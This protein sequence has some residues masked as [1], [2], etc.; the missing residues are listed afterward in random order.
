M[1]ELKISRTVVT[2]VFL[3]SFA[4]LLTSCG[5]QDVGVSQ[6]T[7]TSVIS[8]ADSSSSTILEQTR[9]PFAG[10]TVTPLPS[11]ALDTTLIPSPNPTDTATPLPT[12]SPSPN[13]TD[14]SALTATPLPT[15]KPIPC[16]NIGSLPQKVFPIQLDMSRSHN[17]RVVIAYPY[18]YLAVE[19]Y[20]GIFDITNPADPQLLGFWD[21]PDWPN[22]STLQVHDGIIY[23]TSG[24]TLLIL[25][26]LPQCRF[27]TIA[28]INI[29]IEPFRLAIEGNRLY[30][31]GVL[32]GT[33]KRQIAN[34]MINAIG[35]LQESG[36]VDLGQVPVTWS[37]FEQNIY[38]LG[39]QVKVINVVD[40]NI[41]QIQEVNIALDPQKLRYSPSAFFEDRLYLLWEA[42]QLMIISDLQAEMPIMK[43][44]PKRQAIMGNL[45]YF[46]Y[47]V[48]EHYIFVG[49]YTCDGISCGSYVVF[50]DSMD[51]Q[52]LSAFGFPDQLIHSYYEVQQD[53]VYAFTDAFLLVIDISNITKPAIVT[54]VP[55]IP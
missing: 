4:I 24:R 35:H 46:R 3:T 20:I 42:E 52:E 38:V 13:P 50:Y 15:P 5:A 28:M 34:F 22:I 47:Q 26:L 18:L 16:Q 53:I 31:G 40:P 12:P 51:A 10:N 9:H 55:L 8:Q 43:S 36:T 33:Q 2:F 23:F 45:A 32:P 30:V 27:E 21:F 6:P 37:L 7:S 19:Q 54:E 25:N 39:D 1:I 44:N 29:T 49:G 41:P 48:S 17:Q 11:T 14:T